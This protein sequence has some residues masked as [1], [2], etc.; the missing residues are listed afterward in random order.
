MQQGSLLTRRVLW[1]RLVALVG[2]GFWVIGIGCGWRGVILH[3]PDKGIVAK[4]QEFG[5]AAV[6]WWTP[7]SVL[8]LTVVVMG[9]GIALVRHIVDRD[10]P[11]SAPAAVSQPEL[12]ELPPGEVDDDEAVGVGS[13]ESV[14]T[15]GVAGAEPVEETTELD[16]ADETDLAMADTE[17]DCEPDA[18]A[19]DQD[20]PRSA[21]SAMTRPTD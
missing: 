8:T 5:S 12:P 14:S 4:A 15:D 13:A 18:A 6:V 20:E 2:F 17:A 1:E 9:I 19:P 10:G 16:D 21:G 3:A 11:S 7:A